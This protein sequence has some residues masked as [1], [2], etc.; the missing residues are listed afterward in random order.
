MLDTWFSSALWPFST[1]GWPDETPDLRRYYPT[2]LLITG[3]DILFFWVARM[4]MMGLH[5]TKQ[6]PFRH[7]YLHSLVRNAE[8]QKMSKSKG[9]GIDPILMNEKYGTDAMRFTLAIMSAPGSDLV[10]SE[11][12]AQSYRAFANKIWNAARFLFFNLEKAEASGITIEEL[13]AP[14]IREAAPYQNPDDTMALEDRWIFS[15]L[16]AVAGEV[17]EALAEYRFHEASHVI[18]HFFWGEFCDWYIEWIKPRLAAEDRAAAIAAW[19]NLFA[20][21]ESA[22]RLLHPFMPF[23]TEEL[24]MKLPQ[25]PGVRSIA[26]ERYVAARGECRDAA[27]ERDAALLQEVITLLRNIRAEAKIDPKKK[28]AAE[29]STPS[30]EVRALVAQNRAVIE[31]LAALTQLNFAEG[32][33]PASGGTVRSTAQFDLRIPFD[34][35]I[36]IRAEAAKV[37]KELARL[38]Q[39]IEGKKAKLADEAFRSKAPEHVVKNMEATLSERQAEFAK[40]TE[41]LKQLGGMGESGAAAI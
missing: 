7:V 18:Y 14:E 28:V 1:L 2:S 27:A 35:A 11:E 40:L 5:F 30:R 36:D 38:S 21:F 12:K 29:F 13:A 26:F 23:I 8:G 32:A 37:R 33:L 25:R 16:S 41:R 31:R 22:L 19:R 9:T 24:W 20:M 39:D 3:Y 10:L 6:V 34:E 17:H 4:A 15:R